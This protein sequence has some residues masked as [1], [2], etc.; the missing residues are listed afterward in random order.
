YEVGREKIREYAA[1]IGETSPIYYEPAEARAAGFRALVAP[2]MFCSVYCAPAMARTAFHPDLGVDRA[3]LVHGE[4]CFEWLEP[5]CAGDTIA[6]G[7]E[8]TNLYRQGGNTFFVFGSTSRNQ[9]GTETVR[10]AYTGIVRGADGTPDAPRRGADRMAKRAEAKQRGGAPLPE[11]R[12]TPDKYLPF[13]YAGASGDFTPIHLDAEFARSV[14]LPGII[15]HGLYTMAVV[16]R[17]QVEAVG[18]DPRLLRRLRVRFRGVALPEVE[19]S[20]MGRVRETA[21]GMTIV[22]TRAVQGDTE[23]VGNAEAVLSGP[24]S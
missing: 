7:C 10:G 1:A 21:A 11:F 2:P 13:R 20:V 15:L 19:I 4:Q 9:D 12:V 8:L 23:I 17:A 5:V 16:A 3:R 14:G 24:V 6:T 22:D 18:G